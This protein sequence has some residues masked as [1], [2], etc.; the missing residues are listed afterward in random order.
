MH[1][2]TSDELEQFWHR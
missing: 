2:V 1:Y